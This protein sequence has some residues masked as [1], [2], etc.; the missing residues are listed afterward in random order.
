MIKSYSE[1]EHKYDQRQLKIWRINRLINLFLL[2]AAILGMLLWGSEIGKSLEAWH[3]KKSFQIRGPI[4]PPE[5]IV[6]VSIDERFKQE[7]GYPIPRSAAGYVLQKIADA[8]PKFTSIDLSFPID[9]KEPEGDIIVAKAI[10]SMPSAIASG[11]RYTGETKDS[12]IDISTEPLIEKA[13][14]LQLRMRFNSAGRSLS[15]IRMDDSLNASLYD[16]L[17]LAPILTELGGYQLI[18]PA[19][20]SLINFYGDPGT[21]AHVSSADVLQS[22]EKKLKELFFNKAVF[23]GIHDLSSNHQRST[24]EFKISASDKL[25]FGVEAHATIAGNLIQRNWINRFDLSYEL[26]F[27]L[28]SC[29][30]IASAVVYLSPKIA[31]SLTAIFLILLLIFNFIM[32]TK[33]SCWIPGIL[34]LTLFA[35]V[36]VIVAV[37]YREFYYERLNLYI[38][39]LSS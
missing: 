28:S 11:I 10:A 4:K 27:I 19:P 8:K 26:F 30:L 24:E 25:M 7:V 13:A 32:F 29:V 23:F 1:I 33:F 39:R 20:E 22:S 36:S 31:Y 35:V 18:Q 37:I 17:T 9:P 5:D 14:R 12:V 2:L 3:L 21:I 15:H 16:S 34:S 38:K 6:L